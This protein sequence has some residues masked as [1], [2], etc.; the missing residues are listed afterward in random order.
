MSYVARVR[1]IHTARPQTARPTFRVLESNPYMLS[2]HDPA[3]RIVLITR[4]PAGYP[5][6]N[7]LHWAFDRLLASYATLNRSEYRIIVDTR[8]G[9]SRNDPAFESAMDALRPT[10]LGGFSRVVMIVRTIAGKLQI[11][12]HAQSDGMDVL[13]TTDINVINTE[14]GVWLDDASLADPDSK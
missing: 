8:F 13:V 5:D 12:R 11:T 6:M 14:L 4:R 2:R 9:P 3:A 1:M 10:T 7:T